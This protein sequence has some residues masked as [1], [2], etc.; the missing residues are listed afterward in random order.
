MGSLGKR[1]TWSEEDIFIFIFIFKIN[2][3]VTHEYITT[4]EIQNYISVENKK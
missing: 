1:S 3:K 2:Y 4:E